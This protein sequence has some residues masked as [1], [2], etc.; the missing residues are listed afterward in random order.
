METEGISP[1]GQS[2]A[3]F[4]DEQARLDP[5]FRKLRE[6]PRPYFSLS[7]T[8]LIRRDELEISQRELARRM[9]VSG[10]LISRLER[11]IEGPS[12][13]VARK[14]SEALGVDVTL[15]LP[16]PVERAA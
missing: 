4:F 10:A 5:E 6:K 13:E 2:A 12:D 8:I 7:Q 3:D 15:F 9:G 14:L 16:D 1:I 11:E